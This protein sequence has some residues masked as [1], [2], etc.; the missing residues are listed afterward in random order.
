MKRAEVFTP[1]TLPG[2]TF[3]DEHLAEKRKLLLQNL[4]LGG[5]S[6]CDIWTI[7]VGKDRIRRSDTWV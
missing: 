6:Y 1:N 3:V 2:V 4:E 7:K 5:G